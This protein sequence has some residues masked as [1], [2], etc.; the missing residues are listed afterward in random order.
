[1]K[2]PIPAPDAKVVRNFLNGGADDGRNF[3]NSTRTPKTFGLN[4]FSWRRLVWISLAVRD[5]SWLGVVGL[6]AADSRG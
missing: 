2:D 3:L 5:S 6:I 4:R 1:M